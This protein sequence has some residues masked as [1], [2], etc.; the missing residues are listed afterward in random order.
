MAEPKTNQ[1]KT[2]RNDTG[3]A[4]FLATVDDPKRRADAEAACALM[5]EATGAEPTM[6]GSAII[7][8]G[9]Y[10][11]RYA[12]G[13]EGDAPAVGLSPRKQALT[14]YVSAGLDGHADLLSR[15]G[16]HRT[17]KSCLYLKRLADVDLSVLKEL[18]T[19][20]F[21]HLDG[22]SVDSEQQ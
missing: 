16:P 22:R 18:V 10:H 12:T 11:Y 1:P 3:V 4:E 2:R 5:A 19:R 15:L 13:R 14:L 6:W 20:G 21:R 8:F 7:G 17:G 9:S